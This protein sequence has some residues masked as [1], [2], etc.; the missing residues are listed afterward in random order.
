MV[1][2]ST[3]L[4]IAL[5]EL[6]QFDFLYSQS[7]SRDYLYQVPVLCLQS[8]MV[9]TFPFERC[10]EFLVETLQHTPTE[11]PLYVH[12][13]FIASCIYCWV[14][15]LTYR[16][17]RPTYFTLFIY[18]Y[19]QNDIVMNRIQLS[20]YWSVDVGYLGD[21]GLGRQEARVLL[22]QGATAHVV[23]H[24]RVTVRVLQVKPYRLAQC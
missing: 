7:Y 2:V 15:S 22:A 24:R 5:V 21:G 20:I 13:K 9:C 10:N 16:L 17:S 23:G 12:L 6:S 11:Q 18:A 3:T 4:L 14:H 8:D 1:S 19:S